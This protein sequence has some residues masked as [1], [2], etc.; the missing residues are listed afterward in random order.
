VTRTSQISSLAVISRVS[1]LF[2][3]P[4]RLLASNSTDCNKIGYDAGGD[5]TMITALKTFGWGKKFQIAV[6]TFATFMAL[7]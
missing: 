1:S 6:L 5:N 3:G 2:L 4:K 7:C